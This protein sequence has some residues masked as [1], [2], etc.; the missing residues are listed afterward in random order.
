MAKTVRDRQKTL[1][2]PIFEELEGVGNQELV[3]YTSYL[4]QHSIG[5]EEFVKTL[6]SF[7]KID[8]LEAIKIRKSKILAKPQV[9]LKT[10]KIKNSAADAFQVIKV[11]VVV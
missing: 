5:K 8:Q 1:R 6:T 11:N 3:E 10:K 9:Q 2:G 7:R 4:V